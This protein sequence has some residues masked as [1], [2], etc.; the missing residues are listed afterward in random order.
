[1]IRRE[2]PFEHAE[3]NPKLMGA[4]ANHI[5]VAFDNAL[6][7]TM[8]ITDELTQLFTLRHFRNRMEESIF[9]CERSGQKFSL[10]MLDI[11]HFKSINDRWG[12][13]A[14]DEVLRQVARLLVRTIRVS[15]SAFR[16][17]GEE[18]VILLAEQDLALAMLV[19][20][21]VRHAVENMTISLEDGATIP[22]TVSIGAAI[23]PDDGT[24]AQDLVAAADAALYQAKRAGRNRLQ[25]PLRD[26][27]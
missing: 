19:A 7:Y 4:L 5:G 8:A 3:A 24:S 12:H 15:D 18:F 9:A 11:D 10:L 14:G 26:A 16:Y 21:R 22:V 20:E 2:R 17:G 23:F 6:Y 27:R 1:M 13:P 25:G